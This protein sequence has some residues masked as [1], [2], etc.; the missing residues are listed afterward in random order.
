MKT[1]L[2]IDMCM[3]ELNDEGKEKSLAF[4]VTTNGTKITNNLGAIDPL[5]NRTVKT[6]TRSA[7]WP[8]RIVPSRKTSALSSNDTNLLHNCWDRCCTVDDNDAASSPH[9]LSFMSF[10]LCHT[11]DMPVSWKLTKKEVTPK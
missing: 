7:C 3:Q 1:C 10:N 6:Q 5:I 8:V 11:N 2:S 4:A 9:F